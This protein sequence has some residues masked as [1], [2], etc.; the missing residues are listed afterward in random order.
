M[1]IT[2][3]EIL[4][5]VSTAPRFNAKRP[6]RANVN[7]LLDELRL[8]LRK[9]VDD[10]MQ[11]WMVLLDEALRFFV[12]LERHQHSLKKG[13]EITPFMLQLSRLRSDVLSIRELICI[14]QEAPAHTIA[15]SFLD[16][17]ELA[18]ALAEDPAFAVAYSDADDATQFWRDQIAYGRIYRVVE[19]FLRR[20]GSDEQART[21]VAR[22]KAVKNALSGH[23]HI[24]SFSAFRSGAVPSI[25]HPG[26]IHIGEI[27][28]LSAHM[29][30]LCKLIADE[31][32]VF[33]ACCINAFVRPKPPPVFAAY[34]PSKRL[35][36]VVTSAH[37]LQ[38]FLL[39]HGD[40]LDHAAEAL[41]DAY[42]GETEDAI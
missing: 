24:A 34:R 37:V 5:A 38:E 40:E 33:A 3:D 42:G 21:Y 17:V 14:G 11:P 13:P 26:M 7:R 9:D 10:F 4:S 19:R 32:H 25:S 1:R 36:D 18:M 29:P 2:R 31:T 22:H 39:K 23:V 28:C 20:G 27:G 41:F 8:K 6:A 15:R 16:G 12:Y 35:G 30:R